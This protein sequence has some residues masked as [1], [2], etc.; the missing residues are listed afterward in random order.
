MNPELKKWDYPENFF[1]WLKE[2]EHIYHEFVNLARKMKA[3]GRDRWSAMSIIEI[4]RWETGL[5]SRGDVFKINNTY[6]SGLARLAMVE[7]PDLK[8]FFE[9]REKKK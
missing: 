9:I 1:N 8:G 5:V 6:R 3:T 4:I 7:N 2:N